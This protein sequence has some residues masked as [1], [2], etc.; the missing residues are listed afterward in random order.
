MDLLNEGRTLIHSGKLLRE[1]E[2][3]F[4]WKGWIEVFAW[5]FD[6]Y[7]RWFATVS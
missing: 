3:G 6:N 4:E 2:T 7:R 5:L 1:P